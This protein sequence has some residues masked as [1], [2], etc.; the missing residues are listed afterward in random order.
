[1]SFIFG[2]MQLWAWIGVGYFWA[3]DNVWA[4][5]ACI[6]FALCMGLMSAIVSV[7]KEAKERGYTSKSK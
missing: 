2:F 4:Q 5:I 6:L 3:L 7:G 1:M